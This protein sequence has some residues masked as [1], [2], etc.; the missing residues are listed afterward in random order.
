MMQKKLQQLRVD[1]QIK[2][3]LKEWGKKKSHSL[4]NYLS[5]Q[6]RESILTVERGYRAGM[7]AKVSVV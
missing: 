4:S 7:R 3:L 5:N 1:N 2:T 6:D